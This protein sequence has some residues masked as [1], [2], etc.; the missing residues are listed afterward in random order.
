[1][2]LQCM[3]FWFGSVHIKVTLIYRHLKIN[4]TLVISLV[5]HWLFYHIYHLFIVNGAWMVSSK[6]F[7][8]NWDL[9]INQLS[10]KQIVIETTGICAN[11]LARGIMMSFCKMASWCHDCLSVEFSWF[12]SEFV[13]TPVASNLNWF[14]PTR[15]YFKADNLLFPTMYNLWGSMVIFLWI[16]N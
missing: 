12:L 10:N 2:F 1:M 7:I 3:V 6:C 15:Y 8:R 14:W 11:N 5:Y 16:A 13:I 4:M 9:E